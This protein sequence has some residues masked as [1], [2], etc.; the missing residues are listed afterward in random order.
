M[1]RQGVSRIENFH[2]LIM[3]VF[4]FGPFFE[5]IL[6]FCDILNVESCTIFVQGDNFDQTNCLFGQWLNY[7][8]SDPMPVPIHI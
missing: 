1:E 7:N 5:S 4:R 3:W 8:W 2:L 6:L